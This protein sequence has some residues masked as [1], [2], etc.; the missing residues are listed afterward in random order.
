VFRGRLRL[1]R[2][3]IDDLA[4]RLKGGAYE[5]TAVEALGVRWQDYQA[6]RRRAQSAK[7]GSLYRL[8]C[9]CVRQSKAFARLRAELELSKSDCK[10]W[11]LHGPG[12]EAP[13][14]PG[15]STAGK[16]A[17]GGSSDEQAKLEIVLAIVVECLAPYP[18]AHQRALERIRLIFGEDWAPVTPVPISKVSHHEPG[19]H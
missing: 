9:D 19:T 10:A 7:P 2:Q 11:L 3:F 13:S 8:L 17:Q 5:Q 16:P 1:T 14:R 12:R 18:D 6:W 15:W 4:A